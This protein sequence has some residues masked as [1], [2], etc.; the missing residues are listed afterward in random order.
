M[1]FKPLV[2]AQVLE[3]DNEMKDLVLQTYN[4]HAKDKWN[5]KWVVTGYSSTMYDSTKGKYVA[6]IIFLEK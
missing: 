6:N 1:I 4:P 2:S 5:Y 3:Q